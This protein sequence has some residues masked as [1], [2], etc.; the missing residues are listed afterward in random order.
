MEKRWWLIPL[1]FLGICFDVQAGP[2]PQWVSSEPIP[3]VN[4]SDF[5]HDDLISLACNIYWEGRNQ[6]YQGMLAIAAV[7]LWRTQDREFP[8]TIAQVVWEKRWS[9]RYGRY[10]PQFQWT[11]DG[12]RDMPFENEQAIWEISWRLARQFAVG[13]DHVDRICPHVRATETMW[14]MLEEQ[15]VKVTRRELR[16]KSYETLMASKLSILAG[17]DPTGGAVMYHANYV[18]PAWRKAYEFV[19]AVDDHLFYRK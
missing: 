16:C 8:G 1:I 18:K 9:K 5:Q 3:R 4:C 13:A 19:C 7:T 11:L 14:A 10:Y 6:S 2:E 17:I 15:G 12:K